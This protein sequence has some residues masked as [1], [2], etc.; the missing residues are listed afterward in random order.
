MEKEIKTKKKKKKDSGTKSTYVHVRSG[1]VEGQIYD[2]YR[3]HRLMFALFG[4]F[5]PRI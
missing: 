3:V 2:I 5:L 4:T 1:G